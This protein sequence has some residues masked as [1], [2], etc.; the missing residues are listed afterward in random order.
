[1]SFVTIIVYILVIGGVLAILYNKIDVDIS[2]VLLI[3]L[4]VTFA[5][6]LLDK[7]YLS[8][9]N[10]QMAEKLAQQ[11]RSQSAGVNE[12]ELQAKIAQAQSTVIRQPWWIEWT[13]GFFWIILIVFAL[14]SFVVEP[15]RIP[16]GSMEPTLVPQD[17]IL[18]NKFSYGLRLPVTNTKLTEGKPLKHGD[19][20]VFRFPRN[21]R[22]TYIKRV[23]GLPGDEIRY[24]NKVLSVNGQPVQETLIPGGYT[25]HERDDSGASRNYQLDQYEETLEGVKHRIAINPRLTS[26]FDVRGNPACNY[27]GDGFVCRVPAGHYFMM[28]DNRDHSFDSRYWGFVP[29]ENIVG[30]AFFIW[31]NPT[32]LK[33]IGGFE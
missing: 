6:W 18:V 9:K 20:V 24:E 27:A 28:G 25:Y 10:R 17:F 13:A 26:S 22:Q 7:L 12:Q 31:L 2:L 11:I 8:P 4:L 19:V 30:K 14:R 16:S 5:Y 32:Q 29:D 33:R 23:V 15:F 1:M 21:E 3:L